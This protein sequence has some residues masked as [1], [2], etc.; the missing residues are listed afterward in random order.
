MQKI[1]SR[2]ACFV[3]SIKSNRQTNERFTCIQKSPTSY[4]TVFVYLFEWLCSPVIKQ[5]DLNAWRL[6]GIVL[7][8]ILHS[9]VYL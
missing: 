7:H 8:I 6:F 9:M 4:N 3:V 2:T 5:F 1:P